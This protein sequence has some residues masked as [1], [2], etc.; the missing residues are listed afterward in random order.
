[1]SRLKATPRRTCRPTK[2][3]K[4]QKKH[5]AAAKMVE[6]NGETRRVKREVFS[7]YIWEGARP[8]EA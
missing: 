1:M 6:D 7:M 3:K 5:T 2:K 4:K 8:G